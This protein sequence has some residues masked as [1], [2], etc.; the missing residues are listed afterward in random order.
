MA[1]S[2]LCRVCLKERDCLIDLFVVDKEEP[3]LAALLSECSG[4]SV[5]QL[6]GKPQFICL[7]CA[8][9]T[10]ISFRLIRLA[11]ASDQHMDML[12]LKATND[13][14]AG[15]GP[16]TIT[17]EELDLP[18]DEQS[19]EW[20]YQPVVFPDSP[21]S[22][23]TM[24]EKAAGEDLGQDEEN[25]TW[26]EEDEFRGFDYSPR[27][28]IS[29]DWQEMN[30]A[31]E[32]DDQPAGFTYPPISAHSEQEEDE[33]QD[34][35]VVRFA[36]SPIPNHSEQGEQEEEDLPEDPEPTASKPKPK[37]KPKRKSKPSANARAKKFYCKHCNK[38]YKDL[39]AHARKHKTD[40]HFKCPKC[41]NFYVNNSSLTAHI[42]THTGERPFTCLY[43]DSRFRQR[44]AFL[45]HVRNM[46]PQKYPYVCKL[47]SFGSTRMKDLKNHIKSSHHD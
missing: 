40:G 42:R 2:K 21:P 29:E 22:S 38:Y 34:Q 36:Y 24:Q 14:Q 6:D 44:G 41:A 19:A 26:D 16:S 39:D 25:P 45:K 33:D 10:R 30:P 13:D 28:Q 11:Q 8:D 5:V 12:R 20:D 43:C 17:K 35:E 46:H 37:P 32:S 31:E 18:E 23:S 15:Q 4:C 27:S 7:M 9:A 3:T 47:C 1:L